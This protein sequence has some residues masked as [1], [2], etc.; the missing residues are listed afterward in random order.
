MTPDPARGTAPFARHEWVIAGRYLRARSR[1]RAVSAIAGFSLAGIMLGVAT[2][3]IVMAVMGGFRDELVKRILGVNAHVMALDR[4]GAFADLP[5]TLARLRAMPGV[6]RAAPIVEGQVMA[7]G[8]A[9]SAGALIRAYA[10]ADLATL[11][12]LAEPEEALG[13]V[14][15]L[16][17]GVALGAGLAQALGLTVGDSVTLISPQGL[18]TPFGRSIKA[19]SY[20]VR[21][22][23]RVGM[24]DYDRVFLFMPIELAQLYLEKEGRADGV[25]IMLDRP[26]DLDALLPDLRAAFPGAVTLWDWRQQN[27]AFLD[28]LRIERVTM[29]IILAMVILVAALNI[30]SGLIMLVKDKGRDIGILRTMGLTRGAVLRVFFLCGAAIG[31]VGT[32]LGVG[33]G[34]LFVLNI[35][36][37]QGWVEA[38]TGGS[39]WDPA[40]RV[41]SRVPATLRAGSVAGAAGLAL[42]LSFLAT[43][44]PAW[45]AAR[46]DPVEA[47]RHD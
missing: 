41:L 5:D 19:R 4:G 44:Y 23:V 2:L 33:L 29:F 39:I 43:L 45:R 15:A 30:V 26:D 24:H 17:D 1:E 16:T 34:V 8:P 10:P 38:L 22:V 14:A 42:G 20:P 9:G 12:A 3:V 21:M 6:A 32:A 27:G 25:E 36:A 35:E 18:S 37:I 11:P 7:S 28:A 46:L 13:D 31:V 47:L 40:T